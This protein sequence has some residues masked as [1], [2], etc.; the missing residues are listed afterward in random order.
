[1][2]EAFRK[3]IAPHFILQVVDK[4]NAL[5]APLPQQVERTCEIFEKQFIITADRLDATAEKLERMAEDLRKKSSDIREASVHLPGDIRAWVQA[6][7]SYNS[8]V[9]FFAP[10]T[11]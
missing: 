9:D 5:D 3:D 8:D 4:L 6:E 7:R 10:I 2:A 1:M 11:K